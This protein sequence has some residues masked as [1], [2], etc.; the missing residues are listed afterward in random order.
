M[1][2]KSDPRYVGR[3]RRPIAWLFVVQ[4]A[5]AAQESSLGAES[6][7]LPDFAVKTN[8]WRYS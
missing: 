4:A 5:T 2:K 8:S 6:S 7:R 1:S 3:S